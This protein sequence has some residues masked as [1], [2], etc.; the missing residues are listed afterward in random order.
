MGTTPPAP[1]PSVESLQA[2]IARLRDRLAKAEDPHA[3]S[4]SLR[5]LER[6]L[7]DDQLGDELGRLS[8]AVVVQQKQGTLTLKLTVKPDED[9]ETRLKFVAD[10]AAKPPKLPRKASVLFRDEQSGTLSRNFPQ[11]TTSRHLGGDED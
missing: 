5:L 1:T 8:E 3:F 6:G 10:F 4:S 11:Q 2:E 7:L 9:D